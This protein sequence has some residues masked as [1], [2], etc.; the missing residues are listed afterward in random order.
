MENSYESFRWQTDSQKVA[1]LCLD[2]FNFTLSYFRTLERKSFFFAFYA[3]PADMISNAPLSGISS[4]RKKER[5]GITI[6]V[7]PHKT[8]MS[9]IFQKQNLEIHMFQKQRQH[10]EVQQ[11]TRGLC[12]KEGKRETQIQALLPEPLP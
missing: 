5:E 1:L 12:T 2:Q 9:Y 8:P 4:G 10:S 6:S 11:I 7:N 3:R